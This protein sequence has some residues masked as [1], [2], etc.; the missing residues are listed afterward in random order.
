M[1]LREQWLIPEVMI[2]FASAYQLVS[3]GKIRRQ[4]YQLNRIC[5]LYSMVRFV[6][7]K[8]SEYC[9]PKAQETHTLETLIMV[10]VENWL[11]KK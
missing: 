10:I 3:W 4:A 9:V 7:P 8:E 1:S 5:K 11:C 2:E 6:L